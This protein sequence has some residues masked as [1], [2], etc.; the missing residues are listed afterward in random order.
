MTSMMVYA[1]PRAGAEVPVL[2]VVART[3]VAQQPTTNP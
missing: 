2:A 3:A 1:M